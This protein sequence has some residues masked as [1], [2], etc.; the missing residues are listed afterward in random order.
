MGLIKIK[1][2]KKRWVVSLMSFNATARIDIK[3]RISVFDGKHTNNHFFISGTS[4]SK[5]EYFSVFWLDLYFF[6]WLLMDPFLGARPS[7]IVHGFQF[8]T[9]HS[10]SVL[11]AFL[12]KRMALT[13]WKLNVKCWKHS[14]NFYVRVTVNESWWKIKFTKQQKNSSACF[15]PVT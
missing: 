6:S 13:T 12:K 7:K 1:Q 4:T 3:C 11:D 8:S 14:R 2:T 15:S 10:T 9:L 5:V